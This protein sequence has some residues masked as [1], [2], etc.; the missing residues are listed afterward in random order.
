MANLIQR[1]LA[2]TKILALEI[3]ANTKQA[4]NE[5]SAIYDLAESVPVD[6]FKLWTWYRFFWQGDF[7]GFVGC[8]VRAQQYAEAEGLE[9]EEVA[10][11][12]MGVNG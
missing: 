10:I 3:N 9:F 4:I 8:M 6:P 1:L 11:N 7:E 5:R 2:E 12:R